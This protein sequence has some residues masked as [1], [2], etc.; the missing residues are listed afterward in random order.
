M[1]SVVLLPTPV[2]VPRATLEIP[3]ESRIVVCRLGTPTESTTTTVCVVGGSKGQVT[4]WGDEAVVSLRL[5]GARPDSSTRSHERFCILGG[6]ADR[7]V[8]MAI[9][10]GPHTLEKTISTTRNTEACFG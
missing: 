7:T 4:T 9:G 5:A 6:Q 2:P 1:W 10:P 3:K 8:A